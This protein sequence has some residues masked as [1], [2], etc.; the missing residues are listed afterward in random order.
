V[1]CDDGALCTVDTCDPATGACDFAPVV[2]DDGNDCTYD[3]CDPASGRCTSEPSGLV[4]VGGVVFVGPVTLAWDPSPGADHWNTYR[5]TIPPTLLGSR[6]P[7][8][9]YDHLCYE[10]ADL[11]GDGT[12]RSRVPG[13]PP[14]GS[15][16][17]FVVTAEGPCGEEPPGVS[18][19]GLLRPLPQPCPTPP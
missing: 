17:Y 12:T 19:S 7:A 11:G 14:L 8:D 10:N 18:S 5:G 16:Y 4:D 2:C 6:D 15:A 13:D 1:I 3:T 9:A